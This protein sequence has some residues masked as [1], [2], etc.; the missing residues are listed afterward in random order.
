MY[1]YGMYVYG[2][3]KT[4]T[5]P[6]HPQSNGMVERVNRILKEYL[7]NVVSEQQKDWDEHIPGFLLAYRSAVQDSISRPT[8]KVIFGTDKTA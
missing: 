7:R 4:R 1:V 6:P 5:M 2:I 3:K 8:A